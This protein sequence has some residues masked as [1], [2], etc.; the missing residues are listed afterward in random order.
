MAFQYISSVFVRVRVARIEFILRRWIGQERRGAERREKV[1]RRGVTNC[2]F[3][4]PHESIKSGRWAQI[5]HRMKTRLKKIKFGHTKDHGRKCFHL[6][7][8]LPYYHYHHLDH[9]K[10]NHYTL[11]TSNTTIS[12]QM[13]P[14][15]L[16][17]PPSSIITT[18]T[19]AATYITT[20]FNNNTTT[21]T[22]TIISIATTTTMTKAASTNTPIT[23]TTTSPSPPPPP[24]P[25][26]DVSFARW[27]PERPMTRSPLEWSNRPG[28]SFPFPSQRPVVLPDSPPRGRRIRQVQVL[29]GP[30]KKHSLL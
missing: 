18:T 3:G 10:E 28:V 29:A 11:T 4:R 26:P 24:S 19:T 20:A 9:Q 30:H 25:A 21:T 16:T 5:L 12:S 2:S 13:L 8:T 17:Q 23:T 14:L 15:A 27:S 7:H 1:H 22:F 6:F